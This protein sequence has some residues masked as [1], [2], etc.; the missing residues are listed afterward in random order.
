MHVFIT[1]SHLEMTALHKHLAVTKT[2]SWRSFSQLLKIIA[3]N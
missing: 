3:L 2:Q 1:Q